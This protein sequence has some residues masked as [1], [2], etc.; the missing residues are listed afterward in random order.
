M[1]CTEEGAYERER[2]DNKDDIASRDCCDAVLFAPAL[3]R[4]TGNI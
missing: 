4:G 2:I 3:V 1:I